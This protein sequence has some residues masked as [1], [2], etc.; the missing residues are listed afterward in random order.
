M[1]ATKAKF[2]SP[3]NEAGVFVGGPMY[4]L[5]LAQITGNID[6][7]TNE[8]DLTEQTAANTDATVLY[9]P[10]TGKTH[11]IDAIAWNYDTTPASGVITV[12]NNAGGNIFSLSVAKAGRGYFE[13]ATPLQEGLGSGM[14]LKAQ[15]AGASVKGSVYGYNHKEL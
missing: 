10:V 14:L 7:I 15:A 12:S 8:I 1:S 3:Q 6:N 2:T 9:A 5:S 11:Q 4:N 13:F